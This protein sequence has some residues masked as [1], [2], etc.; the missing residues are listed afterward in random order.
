MQGR[1]LRDVEW[2][3]I[4]TRCGSSGFRNGVSDDVGESPRSPMHPALLQQRRTLFSDWHPVPYAL[5]TPK[6]FAG[7]LR[8]A[9][10]SRHRL[11]ARPPAFAPV[12]NS[13]L[14]VQCDQAQRCS[15][16]VRSVDFTGAC[17]MHACGKRL[18][19]L[20]ENSQPLPGRAN[21][22]S[23][24]KELRVLRL[25]DGW[26]AEIAAYPLVKRYRHGSFLPADVGLHA[27]QTRLENPDQRHPIRSGRAHHHLRDRRCARDDQ[28]QTNTGRRRGRIAPCCV[29]KRAG[30]R[31]V[32]A[33]RNG[34][35]RR[36]HHLWSATCSLRPGG[37][38]VRGSKDG[39]FLHGASGSR[40]RRRVGQIR[41][42]KHACRVSNTRNANGQRAMKKLRSALAHKPA[43]T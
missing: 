6:H 22:D 21:R 31:I 25:A 29:R 33:T 40:Q 30:R 9:R 24:R 43:L 27:L 42:F 14:R 8:G 16:P 1:L 2:N 12:F 41:A 3:Q 13:Y 17:G 18:W 5:R 7:E 39:N 36:P 19:R 4:F 37:V 35:Q 20:M 10:I 15:K 38:R 28:R 23:A 34:N 26:H 11:T 32:N